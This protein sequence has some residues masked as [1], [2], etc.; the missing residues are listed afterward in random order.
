MIVRRKISWCLYIIYLSPIFIAFLVG[1]RAMEAKM[2]AK[3]EL[4]TDGV[5]DSR[6]LVKSRGRFRGRGL[7]EGTRYS[8]PVLTREQLRQ[9]LLLENDINVMSRNIDRESIPLNAETRKLEALAKEVAK[10]E[11]AIDSYSQESIESHNKLV[12]QYNAALEEYNATIPGALAR[13]NTSVDKMNATVLRF[14]SQCADQAYYIHH[15]E[16]VEKELGFA[17]TEQ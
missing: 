15:M 12:Q 9:C 8:G 2:V 11:A 17:H 3:V 1:P 16:A 5:E 4:S 13:V 7:R 6:V 14:N 10:S